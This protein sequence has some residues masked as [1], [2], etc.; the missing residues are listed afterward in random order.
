MHSLGIVQWN[1][2]RRDHM[3]NPGGISGSGH[4]T[5]DDSFQLLTIL[6]TKLLN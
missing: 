3:G 5:L 4:V 6:A 2:A 1:S